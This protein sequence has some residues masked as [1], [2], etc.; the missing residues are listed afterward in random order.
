M[1]NS[2]LR[3]IRKKIWAYSNEENSNSRPPSIYIMTN[4]SYAQLQTQHYIISSTMLTLTNL[5]LWSAVL[6]PLEELEGNHLGYLSLQYPLW[7]IEG[8]DNIFLGQGPS[9]DDVCI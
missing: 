3:L 9:S 6:Q 5:G 8:E 2:D 1:T 4:E 7:L